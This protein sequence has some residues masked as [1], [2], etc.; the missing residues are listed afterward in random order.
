MRSS[1]A[2]IY[3]N[4]IF[5]FY[6]TIVDIKTDEEKPELWE[7]MSRYLFMHLDINKTPEQIRKEYDQFYEHEVQIMKT[8]L[9][10]EDP[11]IRVENVWQQI[12][13][14]VLSYE[15]LEQVCYSFREFSREKLEIFDGLRAKLDQLRAQ[16]KH[17]YLLSNAQKSYTDNEI[18]L[19]AVREYFDDIFISS[20]YGIKKPEAGFMKALL[21][22]H[23]LKVED[24]VMI[25]NEPGSDGL[26]AERVGMDSIIAENAGYLDKI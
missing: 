8:Q 21:E 24:C 15:D 5:D 7:H 13:G 2:K 22:K 1:H 17:L 4:Y 11:E 12:V 3:S 16:G 23:N 9:G 6:G 19:V 18:D 14:E 20:D 26:V 25:G 10:V